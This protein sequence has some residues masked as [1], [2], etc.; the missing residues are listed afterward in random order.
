MSTPISTKEKACGPCQVCCVALKIDTP[1]LRKKAQVP[2]PH[3]VQKGC[4]I[5]E[6]RPPVC[7]SFLCGWRLLPELDASWRP[8]LNGVMLLELP[9]TQ[10]PKAYRAAGPGWVFVVTDGEKAITPRLARYIAG[11]VAR[12]VAVFLSAMTPRIQLNQQLEPLVAAGNLDGVLGVLRQTHALLLPA[13]TGRGLGR[14]WA[15]YRAQVDRMRAIVEQR[16]R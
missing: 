2:C 5:Y 15:L 4:G 3:L 8:D 9:Q 14:I 11:L 13:R 1:Q 7:R 16:Q 12:R 6:A 10:L